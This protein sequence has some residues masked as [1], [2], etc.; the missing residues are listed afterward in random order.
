MRRVKINKLKINQATA[1]IRT[2]SSIHIYDETKLIKSKK[3]Q[4]LGK[5]GLL[6]SS[7]NIRGGIIRGLKEHRPQKGEDVAVCYEA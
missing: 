6:K 3:S 7:Q 5:P 4:A 1:S 2:V